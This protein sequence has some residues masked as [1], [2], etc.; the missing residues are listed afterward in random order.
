MINVG[1][2]DTRTS[3]THS[4]VVEDTKPAL[5]MRVLIVGGYTQHSESVTL[6]DPGGVILRYSAFF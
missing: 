4:L 1:I 5:V 2:E 6:T 3:V